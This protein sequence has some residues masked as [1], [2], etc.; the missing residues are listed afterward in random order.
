[1]AEHSVGAAASSY[2]LLPTMPGRIFEAARVTM[3]TRKEV[4]ESM[5]AVERDFDH[6]T[7]G[8]DMRDEELEDAEFVDE[9]EGMN[10]GVP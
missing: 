4:R 7:I 3:R 6:P 9:L 1:M 2:R 10:V 5:D 8:N